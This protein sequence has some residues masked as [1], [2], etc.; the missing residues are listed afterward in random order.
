MR[1]KADRTNQILALLT[2]EQKIEVAQLSQILNVSQVTIRKD[3]DEL[4][5]RGIISRVHGY[6]VLRSTDDMGMRIAYHYD[7]KKKIAKKAGEM[8][9]NGE[10]VM[11]ENGSCCA[12]LA[13][14]MTES[15]KDLTIITNSAFIA[16][17]I[18]GKANFQIVLLG[19]IFQQDSQVMVG[20]MVRQAAQNFYV[21]TFFIGTDGYSEKV[22]FTNK[23]Q[24]RAQA[25]RD[26]APQA[27]SVV[28]LTESEKF[29]QRGTVPLGIGEA[30]KTV[31]TDN[32]ISGHDKSLL[33]DAGIRV[34][35]AE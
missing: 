24:L 2:R 21:N 14:A 4:E 7:E 35:L 20:P 18:R 15:H 1:I 6:A 30:L 31:I 9:K 16:S 11:I 32:N 29:S 8:V 33:E 22:G 3:L 23:D 10:T 25:V 12:L 17:Y 34:V 26:M 28:V 19:G 5:N 13:D 27:E